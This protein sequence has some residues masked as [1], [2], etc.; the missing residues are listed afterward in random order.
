MTPMSNP[1]PTTEAQRHARRAAALRRRSERLREQ[2]QAAHYDAVAAD[3][4]YE[5]ARRR[6]DCEA[7]LAALAVEQRERHAHWFELIMPLLLPEVSVAVEDG[8][9]VLTLGT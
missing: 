6:A 2:A 9:L 4:A 8:D 7:A 5:E 3:R 1:R